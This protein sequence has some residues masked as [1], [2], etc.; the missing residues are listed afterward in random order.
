MLIVLLFIIGGMGG[1]GDERAEDPTTPAASETSSAPA[2]EETTD[3]EASPEA[4]KS[5]PVLVVNAGGINGLAGTW[6]D[7]LEGEDWEDVSLSTADNQQQE[8]VVFYRDDE[9]QETAQ[10]LA[11]EVGAGEARQSDEYDSPVTFVAVEMPDEGDDGDGGGDG[12]EG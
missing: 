3:E 2:D 8:P 12:G 10:A 9:D 11:D 7:A 6:Q 1:D 4:D 5:V